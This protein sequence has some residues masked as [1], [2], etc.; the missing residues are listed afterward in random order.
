MGRLKRIVGVVLWAAIIAA[1]IWV[2]GSLRIQWLGYE[3]QLSVAFCLVLLML[4]FHLVIWLDRAVR[5]VGA[6]PSRMQNWRK[7]GKESDA[8]QALIGGLD[9]MAAD[10][11][12]LAG[13]RIRK[14]ASLLGEHEHP[15]RPMLWMSQAWLATCKGDQAEADGFYRSLANEESTRHLGHRGLLGARI[16]RMLKSEGLLQ[17]DALLEQSQLALKDDAASSLPRRAEIMAL[18]RLGHWEEALKSWKQ[19]ARYEILPQDELSRWAAAIHTALARIYLGRSQ[20]NYALDEAKQALKYKPG[21]QGAALIAFKAILAKDG[22]STARRFLLKQWQ[23]GPVLEMGAHFRQETEEQPKIWPKTLD[24]LADSNEQAWET[25]F[26][27][28]EYLAENGKLA[29]AANILQNMAPKAP[30]PDVLSL[31]ADV[32]ENMKPPGWRETVSQ[33]HVD[34]LNPVQRAGWH[35]AHC[36][37]PHREWEALC[38]GCLEIG[39]I[40][41]GLHDLT[42]RTLMQDEPESHVLHVPLPMLTAEVE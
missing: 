36:G 30:C 8:I 16:K 13:K 32:V 29:E 33:L 27:R 14:A 28:A 20:Y 22:V 2:P 17:A 19:A 41:Y 31:W 1:A 5:W 11:L 10:D 6:L 7:H 24:M 21:F 42:Q 34:M 15:L 26:L 3:V 40:R 18:I 4:A 35:C 23:T 12:A 38:Q 37:T 39:T 9:A 25:Q